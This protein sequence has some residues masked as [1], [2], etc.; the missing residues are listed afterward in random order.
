M[1]ARK[2]VVLPSCCLGHSLPK[3]KTLIFTPFS[4]QIQQRRALTNS[5]P[6]YIAPITVS[7]VLMSV[8]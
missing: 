4:M 8:K 5:V 2:I 7:I 3:T 1:D 6:T